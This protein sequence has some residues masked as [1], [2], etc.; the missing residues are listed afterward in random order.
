MQT[1]FR[2]QILSAY[3]LKNSG[4]G[5]EEKTFVSVGG[6]IGSFCWVNILRVHGVAQ[7]NIAVVAQNRLAYQ[8]F[9]QYC[10]HSG[11]TPQDRL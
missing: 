2:R 5:W 7:S 10:D 1:F 8:Q 6:G 4:L 9:K 11:L 3:E